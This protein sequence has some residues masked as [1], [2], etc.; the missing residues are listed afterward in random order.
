LCALSC[1]S[2]PS[3][4][5]RAQVEAVNLMPANQFSLHAN[6]GCK[7]VPNASFP[8]VGPPLFNDCDYVFNVTGNRGC[9]ITAA[10]NV[11]LGAAFAKVR[12]R[13][14]VV[15]W[16]L[17]VRWCRTTEAPM[18]CEQQPCSYP[19]VTH[20]GERIQVLVRG[21]HPDVVLR[22]APRV[23]LLLALS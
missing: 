13:V 5:Q 14:R 17:T 7:L 9:G 12:A 21:R 6:P 3:N 20:N 10:S 2:T 23:Q 16:L 19:R 8:S 18:R 1:F 15:A 11:S 22:G 4:A